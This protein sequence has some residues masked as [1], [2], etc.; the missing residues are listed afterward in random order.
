MF[1]W[2]WE[3]NVHIE[4]YEVQFLIIVYVCYVKL[5]ILYHFNV[6]LNWKTVV[7]AYS[8]NTVYLFVLLTHFMCN[9]T[10]AFESYTNLQYSRDTDLVYIVQ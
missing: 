5:N 4:L 2:D 7:I 1:I 9:K 10:T 6:R 8:T 3:W